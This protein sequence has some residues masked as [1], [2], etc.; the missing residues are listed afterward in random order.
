MALAFMARRPGKYSSVREIVEE[1]ET[2]RRLLA[3]VLKDLSRSGL[4]E[5]VRGPGGGYRL[6]RPAHKVSVAE[7]VQVLEGPVAV[8]D[9]T[10]R[11]CEF[12]ASCTIQTGLG[13]VAAGIQQVL[14]GFTLAQLA[15]PPKQPLPEPLAV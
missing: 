8:A 14:E 2:P 5:A 3:E 4:V 9:C 6:T 1:L 15:N 11:D 10:G 13:R 12:L 7:V